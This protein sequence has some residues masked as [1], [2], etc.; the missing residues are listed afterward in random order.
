MALMSAG[1][2]LTPR[3]GMGHWPLEAVHE[4]SSS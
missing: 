1:R 2:P 4:S 3:A